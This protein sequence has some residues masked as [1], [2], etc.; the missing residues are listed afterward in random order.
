MKD[1]AQQCSAGSVC[2]HRQQQSQSHVRCKLG[3]WPA[4]RH[5][6]QSVSANTRYNTSIAQLP[7]C[8]QW[9]Q[10]SENTEQE[11]ERMLRMSE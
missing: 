2:W 10:T 5:S 9:L 3:G 6:I 11:Q 4:R 7:G 1:T 8:G